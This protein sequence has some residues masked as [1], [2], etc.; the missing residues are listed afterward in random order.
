MP[1]LAPVVPAVLGAIG[2]AKGAVAIGSS[3]LGGV[4]GNRRG[5]GETAA[6][7]ELQAGT[8]ASRTAGQ[9]F[10]SRSTNPITSA[11]GF[12]Q[13]LLTRGARP[14]PTALLGP[15][16]ASETERFDETLKAQRELAP[17][18]GMADQRASDL[19]F[20]K[21]ASITNL[22]QMLLRDREKEDAAMRAEAPGALATLGT[23]MANLGFQGLSAGQDGNRTLLGYEGN[24]RSQAVNMG[25]SIGS[26][27][28]R[29]LFGDK[30]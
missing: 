8:E 28:A 14:S 24:R 4:L 6:A 2:G 16:I 11:T 17:R 30:P 27:L 13:S 15:E 19:P 9:D 10:L 22:Y 18:S 20:Q 1:F 23:N 21:A 29:I 26:T 25:A 3:I 5:G 12:W 7:R